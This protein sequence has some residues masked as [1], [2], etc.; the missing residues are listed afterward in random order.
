[1]NLTISLI[2]SITRLLKENGVI[3]SL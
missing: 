1:M 2:T 3:P